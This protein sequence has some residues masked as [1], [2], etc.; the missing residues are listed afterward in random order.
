M[1]LEKGQKRIIERIINVFE[2]GKPEG[3]YGAIAVFN[4]GPHDIKQITYGRSQTTEYGNLRELVRMY[5]ESGGTYSKKLKPYAE[6]I[7]SVPLTDDEKFRQL[8]KDAGNN[9]PVMRGV[10]DKFFEKRYFNPAMKWAKD[11]EFILPLSALVIYDS[12]IHSG[13]MLW[14][15]R[16]MFAEMPPNLGGNEI[17][18][19]IAYVNARHRWL[20]NHHREIVRKTIYRTQTFKD[21]IKRG[22]WLL[23]QV[24]VRANGVSVS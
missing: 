17:E 1:K 2:T 19:T 4:D 14:V 13:S 11:H 21:E 18:W 12:Y 5:V 22:N 15:I 20:Q 9:D 7:G 10:Q 16:Q 6:K 3:K 8:L 23:M 24:P